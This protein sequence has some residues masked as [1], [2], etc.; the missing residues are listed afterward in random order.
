MRRTVQRALLIVGVGL[1]LGLAANTVSP[2]RIPFI[3]APKKVP[4]P[5]EFLS[6]DQ[7]QAL[8]NT[9]AAFFLDARAPA[10]YDAGHIAQAFNL[11]VEAFDEYF[12]QVAPML[13]P[14]AAIVVYCDGEA[15]EL[16]HRLADKLRPLG[17]RNVRLLHNGWTEWRKA[18]FATVLPN[19]K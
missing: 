5:G 10:D 19:T 12:P 2:R 4:L 6:L 16:S 9:G 11:P 13:S 7:A 17:Y 1:T 18:G 8:W 3:T 14:D 15:C